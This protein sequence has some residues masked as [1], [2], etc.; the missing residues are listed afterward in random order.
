MF[1]FFVSVHQ[2]QQGFAMFDA[3]RQ[4]SKLVMGLLFVLIIPSFI[5]VGINQGYFMG[6][7]PVVAVV[8]GREITQAQWDAAHVAES[9]RL[10]MG[11]PDMDTQLLDTPQARWATLERLVRE[12]VYIA[13]ATRQ[14][15]VTTDAMLA[16]TLTDIPAIASLRRADGTLDA[17]GY[18]ALLAAQGMTPEQFEASVRRDLSLAQ[19]TGGITASA[20]AT[21][22]VAGVAM[23]AF[24]Q[25]RA[26]QVLHLRPQ[27][28]AARVQPTDEDLQSYY[29]GHLEQFRQA[30][31]ADIE[32]LELTLDALRQRVHVNEEDLRTYYRE[33]GPRLAGG[34][35]QRRASH[36]LIT[37]AA[38]AP[39]SERDA[40]RERAQALRD[41]LVARPTSF[42]EV[43]RKQSQDPGSASA[44]GDLGYFAR[45]AMVPE[46]EQ[47]AFALQ[48]G[49]ISEVVQTEFGYHII[50]LTD[51]KIPPLPDFATLRPKI[52]ADLRDEMARRQFAE[53]AETFANLVYEQ[54]D[55]LQAAASDLGLTIARAEGI[56]RTPDAAVQTGALADA[57]FLQAIFSADSLEH[58][59]NTDAVETA[60][61][62][63][64]AGRVVQYTPERQ[65]PLQEVQPQV[66][67]DFV[68]QRSAQLA[69]EDGQ[70]KLAQWKADA[71]QAQGLGAQ[72]EVSREQPGG[73]DAAVLDA[74]L[75]APV[76][77]LPA[78]EGVDAGQD[79]Y[80][81]VRV[82]GVVPSQPLQG[83]RARAARGE[84]TQ[85]WA[86]AEEAAYY[87]MLK[88][89]FNVSIK[90]KQP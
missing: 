41:Q 88:K 19:V 56:T 36:I 50:A 9:D 3:I 24:A 17:Q 32:Y 31:R 44:G 43:A 26:V 23:D 22:A 21:D 8:D 1:A 51:I 71:A 40:A 69:R 75:S 29:Q 33:N 68:A 73:L 60:P 66:R 74:V 89:Q 6:S 2:P 81:I 87:E 53:A 34:Q 39:Q 70:S 80:F 10:R 42:A 46:F 63:L 7:S 38:D 37:V 15:L 48:K 65:L 47:A 49:G 79:G 16:R 61:S 58:K 76:S 35:E 83:D 25:R 86:Q 72:M 62:H 78:W 14:H 11:N 82:N 27:D 4:H 5:F 90:V 30:E 57:K 59:R 54:S 13:A 84:Y 45:G 18:R 28:Y 67:G 20:L 64:I 55:S 12:Q 52:E 77:N 85:L